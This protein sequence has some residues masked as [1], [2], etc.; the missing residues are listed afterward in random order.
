MG[1]WGRTQ[2]HFATSTPL[3]TNTPQTQVEK[4][5]NWVLIHSME[6]DAGAKRSGSYRPAALVITQGDMEITIKKF[7]SDGQ[8]Q[9][10]FVKH[11][12]RA[13]VVKHLSPAHAGSDGTEAEL[14]V[15]VEEY[16]IRE[17]PVPLNTGEILYNNLI[18]APK[19]KNNRMFGF[20]V[21]NS[22][23]GS[24]YE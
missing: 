6:D 5:S 1:Y 3:A 16:N 18:L 22:L 10:R 2:F 7:F 21:V 14:Q 8:E 9:Y 20:Y 11:L 19:Y 12:E 23:T 17:H 4:G 13:L 15:S 24:I